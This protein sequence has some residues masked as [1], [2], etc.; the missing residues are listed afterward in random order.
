LRPKRNLIFKKEKATKIVIPQCSLYCVV[1]R[2]TA[3][4]VSRP[5]RLSQVFVRPGSRPQ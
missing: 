5:F 3:I 2:T 4:S 1:I